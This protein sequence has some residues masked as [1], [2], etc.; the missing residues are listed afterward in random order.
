M[1]EEAFAELAQQLDWLR[2]DRPAGGFFDEPQ[3]RYLPTSP[4]KYLALAYADLY[5][6]QAE[7]VPVF[8]ATIPPVPPR[9]EGYLPRA[10]LAQTDLKDWH[11]GDATA[12]LVQFL[13]EKDTELAIFLDVQ[14][15]LDG[16]GE[17]LI[18]EVHWLVSLCKVRSKRTHMLVV[19]DLEPMRKAL[20]IES[21]YVRRFTPIRLPGMGPEPGEAEAEQQLR[22]LLGIPDKDVSPDAEGS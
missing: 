1:D 3:F 4:G 10:I 11:R 15:L 7:R 6:P 8:V 22:K 18:H 19:G 16:A 21:G 14:N 13:Q 12:R 17:P 2:Q 5:P 9:R 20:W